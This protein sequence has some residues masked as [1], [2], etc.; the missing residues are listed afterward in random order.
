MLSIRSGKSG[1]GK[2]PATNERSAHCPYALHHAKAWHLSGRSM[3]KSTSKITRG[4]KSHDRTLTA[5]NVRNA[6]VTW[7]SFRQLMQHNCLCNMPQRIPLPSEID[8]KKN[9]TFRNRVFCICKDQSNTFKQ[10]FQV[11]QDSIPTAMNSGQT[12]TATHVYKYMP[13]DAYNIRVYI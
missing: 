4:E 9:G 1:A 2:T 13:M 3:S 11:L 7:C 10:Y 8:P 5:R 12:S 6:K